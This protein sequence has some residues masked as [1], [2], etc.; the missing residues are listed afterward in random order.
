[1]N[2]FAAIFKRGDDGK[3]RF[4]TNFAKGSYGLSYMT[5]GN[6]LTPTRW[7]RDSSMS[8]DGTYLSILGV[9]QE[10]IITIFKRAGEGDEYTKVYEYKIHGAVGGDFSGLSSFADVEFAGD[11]SFFLLRGPSDL[12][13]IYKSGSGE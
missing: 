9:S 5:G 13:R 3:Y 10:N 2:G 8:S 4:V 12:N 11:G 6:G 7:A 1:M